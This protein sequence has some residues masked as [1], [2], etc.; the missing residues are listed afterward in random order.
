MA[1]FDKRP[2]GK[3]RARVRRSD[4]GSVSRSFI[5]KREA[6]KWARVMEAHIEGGT[7]DPQ[8]KGSDPKAVTLGQL[9]ERY[10]DN[11]STRK[12]GAKVEATVLNAFLRNHAAMAKKKLSQIS[13]TDWVQ[14]RD[15]RLEQVK[16]TT[17]RRQ[18]N[19]FKNFYAIII[20]EWGYEIDNHID[21]INLKVNDVKRDRRLK[22]GEL[23]KLLAEASK[24][25]NKLLVP[26][27][28]WACAT[29]M[30][31]GEILN[32]RWSDIDLK[33]K[34]LEVRETKTGVDRTLPVTSEMREILEQIDPVSE[35]VFPIGFENLNGTWRKIVK[36][37]GIEDLHFHD[38]RREGVSCLFER[39]LDIPQV[40]SISGH[41][42]WGMLARYTKLK[43]QDILKK[44]EKEVA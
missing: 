26:L 17:L 44:L 37:C 38:L 4:L 31:R 2:N 28:K 30:R 1:S 14:Y 32:L 34:V 10:R 35:Y 41:K 42:T 18:W 20:S 11:I 12:K 43:P 19:T 29:A 39:G 7:Y 25:K 8:P 9:I 36:A 22:D 15:K 23:D 24:R 27:I 33:Q 3:W 21:K 5:S 40:A 16:P 6:E 13:T